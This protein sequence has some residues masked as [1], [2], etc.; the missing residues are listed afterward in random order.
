MRTSSPREVTADFVSM[1][2][3]LSLYTSKLKKIKRYWAPLQCCA[4]YLVL[5]IC[6]ASVTATLFTKSYFHWFFTSPLI[7]L[8]MVLEV[9]IEEIILDLTL[10]IEE[11][12]YLFY[13]ARS[14]C[15]KKP[16]CSTCFLSTGTSC[17]PL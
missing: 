5:C 4:P 13:I 9:V 12:R 10:V 1:E 8:L 16:S 15:I 2:E 14:I 3:S 6:V 11:S 7:F 17:H